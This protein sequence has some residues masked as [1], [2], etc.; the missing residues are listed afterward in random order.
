[1]SVIVN[2]LDSEKKNKAKSVV[3]KDSDD[4]ESLK[5]KGILLLTFERS[6]FTI[7]FALLSKIKA[8]TRV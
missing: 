5:E 3:I 7:S 8:K 4:F 1:M 6:L 2:V